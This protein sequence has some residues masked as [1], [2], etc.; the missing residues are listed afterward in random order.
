MDLTDGVSLSV[1][2]LRTI[3]AGLAEEPLARFPVA[4]GMLELA[5]MLLETQQETIC[6]LRTEIER[7]KRPT[8]YDID[9]FYNDPLPGDTDSP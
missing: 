2:D 4:A 6:R 9:R 7:L 5:A 1:L 3:A 8:C